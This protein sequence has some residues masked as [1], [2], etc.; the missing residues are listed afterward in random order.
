M[1][2]NVL[3]WILFRIYVWTI[4]ERRRADV[5]GCAGGAR[6]HPVHSCADRLR[7]DRP[8]NC[9]L[10]R[11]S[12]QSRRRQSRHAG[13]GG[14]WAGGRG[15]SGQGKAL[16]TQPAPRGVPSDH[17]ARRTEGRV[18]SAHPRCHRTMVKASARCRR[19]RFV[20]SW[21]V[22]RPCQPHRP[23][24]GQTRSDISGRR[25]VGQPGCR[26]VDRCDRLVRQSL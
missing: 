12:S 22:H 24:R 1:T 21:N 25:A 11:R 5:I 6:R 8:V 20:R 16:L 15:A 7:V 2:T 17:P 9:W 23:L 10:G 3:I 19:S 18:V 13:T 4:R 26:S 14:R